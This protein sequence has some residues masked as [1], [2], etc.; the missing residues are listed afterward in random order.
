[1]T[2]HPNRAKKHI[3]K[4]CPRG[5]QNETTYVSVSA[6][7]FAAADAHLDTLVDDVDDTSCWLEAGTK[8]INGARIDYTWP[9]YKAECIDRY[10]DTE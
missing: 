1:M 7:D 8:L 5:F 10:A 9:R 3:L 6:A 2:N 4:I